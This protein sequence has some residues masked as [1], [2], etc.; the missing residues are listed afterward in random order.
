MKASW[1]SSP[2]HKHKCIVLKLGITIL[3]TALAL[4]VF[5]YR[6]TEFQPQSPLI[7]QTK[8]TPITKS[9]A[10]SFSEPVDASVDEFS[11]PTPT[12]DDE[13][14]YKGTDFRSDFGEF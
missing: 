5:L 12:F 13:A 14:T 2:I 10:T 7:H 1:K 9:P 4:R 6:S 3:A 11:E 8:S